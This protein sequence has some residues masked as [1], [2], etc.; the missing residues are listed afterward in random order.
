MMS[1]HRVPAGIWAVVVA[2]GS[3]SRFGAAKQYEPLG[4]RR[5][6]DWSVAAASDGSVGVVLVVSPDRLEL[7]TREVAEPSAGRVM[8]VAGAPTRSG[9]VRAGLAAVPGDAEV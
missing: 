1:Q 8:V 6:V 7:D 4:D 3:G 5:V 2:A 9:S